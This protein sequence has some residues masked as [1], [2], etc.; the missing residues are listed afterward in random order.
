MPKKL[1]FTNTFFD[2]K[3]YFYRFQHFSSVFLGNTLVTFLK[4][5][6]RHPLTFVLTYNGKLLQETKSLRF[7][8]IWS[9]EESVGRTV[10]VKNKKV[11][12]NRIKK[13]VSS[14]C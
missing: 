9:A 14:A 8:D 10:L 2:L 13:Y 6:K 3:V 11:A 1:R 7:S 5:S 4:L 12:K